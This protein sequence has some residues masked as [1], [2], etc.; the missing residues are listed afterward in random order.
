MCDLKKLISSSVE[1]GGGGGG[2]GTEYCALIIG[3]FIN[4]YAAT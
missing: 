4:L 1:G 3:T 2:E